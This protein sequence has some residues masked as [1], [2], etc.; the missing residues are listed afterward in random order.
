MDFQILAE[1]AFSKA[2]NN[3]NIKTKSVFSGLNKIFFEE[4]SK[5]IIKIH[6]LDDVK[7]IQNEVDMCRFLTDRNFPSNKPIGFNDEYILNIENFYVTFWHYIENST[8]YENWTYFAKSFK[9]FH[10]LMQDYNT[11]EEYS[12][13]EQLDRFLDVL[14]QS[15]KHCNSVINK[16]Q[17]LRYKLEEKYLSIK[18]SLN[19]NGVHLDIHR[20]NILFGKD[21]S[22]IID[23]EMA[24]R[25]DLRIDLV[26]VYYMLVVYE[27]NYDAY[28]EFVEAYGYDVREWEHFDLFLDI[29]QLTSCGWFYQRHP[30]YTKA[31]QEVKD[32]LNSIMTRTF[33]QYKD[34]Y[35]LH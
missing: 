14:I 34:L 17:T 19:N 25:T 15:P 3:N 1:K 28:D 29:M 5:T 2:F 16:I 22:Y 26:Y 20:G 10:D 35:D 18:D 33:I 4:N 8:D 32:R 9:N 31:E 6:V 7:N 11:L 24:R 27:L 30:E 13:F 23:C 21:T 12:P